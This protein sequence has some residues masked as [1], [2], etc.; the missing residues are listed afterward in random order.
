MKTVVVTLIALCSVMCSVN[1]QK[2]RK[3]EID[4][5]TKAHVV[6][7]SRP[8]VNKYPGILYASFYKNGDDEFLRLYWEC[9]GIISMDKGNKVIFLDVEGNP[10]TFYNSQYIMSEDIHATSNNLGS[11]YIL[12]MWLVG[13]LGIFE[14]KEL[15]AI[16]IYTNQGYEDIKLGKRIAKLKELYS[17]YKSALL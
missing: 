14:D 1:A 12:E 9:S 4:K 5:F 15:A 7:T 2:I 8:L 6:E 11:E 10:Y 13:D 3:N 17:V 16:R